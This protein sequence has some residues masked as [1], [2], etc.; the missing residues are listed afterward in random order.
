MEEER[1]DALEMAAQENEKGKEKKK[2]QDMNK[3]ITQE[4]L[5]KYFFITKEALDKA[6][7][8]ISKE[9]RLVEFKPIAEEF[10]DMAQRYFDDANH[11]LK[12]GDAVTAFAALNYAHGWLDA[13]ARMKLFNVKDSRLFASD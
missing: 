9:K 1:A 13:G 4:R 8:N 2:I 5:D 7:S 3:S 6:R 11:F 12:N 10:L